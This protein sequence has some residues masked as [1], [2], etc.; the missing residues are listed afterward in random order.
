MTAT[1]LPQLQEIESELAA[2]EE[3]LS[4]QLAIQ[5]GLPSCQNSTSRDIASTLL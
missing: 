3:S 2:Q 4:A 1:I 5:M